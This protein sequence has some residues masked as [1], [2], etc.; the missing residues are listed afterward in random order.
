M[1]LDYQHNTFKIDNA[2]THQILLKICMDTDAYAYM[3][4]KK[5]MQDGQAVYFNVCKQYLSP[6]H[7][8]WEATEAESKLQTCHYDDEKKGLDW[9]QF[10]VVHNEQLTLMESLTNYGSKDRQLN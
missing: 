2:L 5:C 8:I 1:H 6:Y 9:D 7:V 4:Q 3:K 10:V